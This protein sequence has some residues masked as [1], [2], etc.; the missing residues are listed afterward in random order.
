MAGVGHR[1][2]TPTV[3]ALV[4]RLPT[5][6][7]IVVD[8]VGDILAANVLARELFSAFTVNDNL[9][10]P[11]RAMWA[12]RDGAVGGGTVRVFRHREM[13]LLVVDEVVLCSAAEPGTTV[14]V[15]VPAPGSF[16]DD[17]LRI[18]GSLRASTVRTPPRLR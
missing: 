12:R 5:T 6:P 14:L 4:D 10:H 2:W 16:S 3:A 1:G 15:Y 13:G 18:L 11:Y 9:V 17:A 8:A 7:A